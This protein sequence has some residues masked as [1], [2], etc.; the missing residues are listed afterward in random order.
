[1]LESPSLSRPPSVRV[2]CLQGRGQSA[3]SFR[4]LLG[5]LIGQLPKNYELHFLDAPFVVSEEH[6][7][8]TEEVQIRK[9]IEVCSQIQ[10]IESR[11][12]ARAVAN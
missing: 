5:L 2:L 1:M 6:D 8:N 9:A 12:R 3:A 7:S 10:A 11:Q 4:A